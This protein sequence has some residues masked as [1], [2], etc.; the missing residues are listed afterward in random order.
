MKVILAGDD[1]SR[2]A[3]RAVEWAARLAE[4]RNALLKAV[5]AVRAET[6]PDPDPDPDDR[7][8]RIV[9]RDAHPAATILATAEEVDADL[10]VLGR[11]GSGGFPSLPIGTTAHTVAA[12]SGRPAAIV[13]SFDA[14]A[15]EPLVRRIVVGVDGLP[16]SGDA[17]TWAARQWPGAQFT[18]VHALELAPSFVQIPDD[19]STD[20][21]DRA[22]ARS[23][24][25]MQDWWVRPLRD[26]GVSFDTIVEDGGPAEVLLSITTRM[27][28]D[29]VVVGRRDHHLLRG[30]LGGVS[31]RVLAYA[32]CP[33]VVVPSL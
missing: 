3:R 4:E 6:A 10:I 33:T 7:F 23:L 32:P 29:V 21:Y 20:L 24:Q 25:L 5:S 16:G 17:V 18:A 27:S 28:A 12:S 15:D 13:P 11:R 2:A 26:A 30:T 1:G 19:P 22:R 9:V 31:Q 14:D 8:E